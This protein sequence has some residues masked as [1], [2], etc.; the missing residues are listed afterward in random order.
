LGLAYGIYL[1]GWELSRYR[2]SGG[3]ALRE[4]L[5][6]KYYLDRLALWLARRVNVGFAVLLDRFDRRIVDGVVN[7]AAT[8]SAVLGTRLRLT[9]SG[10]VGS[11]ASWMIAG[12]AIL[13]L[14]YAL[15]R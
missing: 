3:V 4:L 14:I 2:T 1:R 10:Y 7:G 13:W 8:E 9:V 6:Q 5:V 15:W 11:Y 12:I